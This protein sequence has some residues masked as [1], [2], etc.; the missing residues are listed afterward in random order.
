M[1]RIKQSLTCC[2]PEFS[3][4]DST[5]NKKFI[6]HADCCQCGLVCANNFC[7][8][9]SEVVFNIYNAANR[10]APC[11][12]ITKK[13][14][15]GAELVT[16]ADSYQVIFPREANPEDK[17]ILIAAGLMI[18]YQFFEESVSDKKNDNE[19]HHGHYRNY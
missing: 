16:S 15:T 8:K 11:G 1:G 19:H 10:S 14:A 18:D 3:L 5:G 17:M 13:C 9:L 2:D 4:Y 12:T 7:G 6:I